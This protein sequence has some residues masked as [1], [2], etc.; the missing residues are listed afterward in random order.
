MPVGCS[1]A[2]EY[3]VEAAFILLEER[4]HLNTCHL[5]GLMDI[6]AEGMTGGRLCFGVQIDEDVHKVGIFDDGEWAVHASDPFEK[7]EA[8]FAFSELAGDFVGNFGLLGRRTR[9]LLLVSLVTL[10]GVRRL[11]G[12]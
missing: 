7:L 12:R 1:P 3:R 4:L 9:V 8:E 2:I 11:V 10:G 6:A 5:V